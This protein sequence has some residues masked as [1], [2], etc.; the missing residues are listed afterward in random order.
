MSAA[1]PPAA[2]TALWSPLTAAAREGR[3]V[4]QRCT[5]CGALQYPPREVCRRCLSDELPWTAADGGGTV[6]A[7]TVLH[8]SLEPWFTEH[9]PWYMGKVQLDAGPWIFAHLARDC[10]A[11]GTR[12]EVQARIDLGGQAV[13]IALAQGATEIVDPG[14]RA[15]LGL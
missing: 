14:L 15:L 4:L 13:L 1:P 10:L 5:T 8:A 11:A 9:L 2:R 12:V 7:A 6:L 3:F